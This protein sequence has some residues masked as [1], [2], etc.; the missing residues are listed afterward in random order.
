MFA[1]DA[2]GGCLSGVDLPVSSIRVQW[3]GG[4]V[5]RGLSRVSELPNVDTA[6]GSRGDA[7]NVMESSS[8]LED[9]EV[10]EVGV[11]VHCLPN[12]PL[13]FPDLDITQVL[14]RGHGL[15]EVLFLLGIGEVVMRVDHLLRVEAH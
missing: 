15:D 6:R 1:L 11:G 3:V 7:G 2:S 14:S 12:D 4:V 8:S 5:G 9:F 10:L 13:H